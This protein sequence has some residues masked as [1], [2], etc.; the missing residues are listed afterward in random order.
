[1]T[2]CTPSRIQRSSPAAVRVPRSGS[3][4][5]RARLIGSWNEQG[6]NAFHRASNG[7][8]DGGNVNSRGVDHSRAGWRYSPA[9]RVWRYRLGDQDGALSRLKHGFESRYRYSSPASIV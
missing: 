4:A 5:T 1:M 7:T 8:K 6:E 3:N 2:T 9:S